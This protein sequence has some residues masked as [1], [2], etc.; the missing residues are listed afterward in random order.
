M[1]DAWGLC[2][3]AKEFLGIAFPVHAMKEYKGSTGMAPPTLNFGT[4]WRWLVNF[5]LHHFSPRKTAPRTHGMEAEWALTGIR[6]RTISSLRCRHTYYD[7]PNPVLPWRWKQQFLRNIC[8][9]PP[10]YTASHPGIPVLL[11][12]TVWTANLSVKYRHVI[13]LIEM[14]RALKD[15][16]TRW[17]R[18]Q[19]RR[20]AQLGRRRC[21][22]ACSCWAA[23]TFRVTYLK[24]ITRKRLVC[25]RY[26][27][28]CNVAMPFTR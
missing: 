26:C 24:A 1:A 17:Q 21:C 7:G 11:L 6:M 14:L 18:A 9:C 12:T 2:P 22:H 16:E 25:K 27:A 15:A 4:R 10:N 23:A 19:C 3:A 5:T 28:Y 13:K 20:V 8:T